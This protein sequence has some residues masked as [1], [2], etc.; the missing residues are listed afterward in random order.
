MDPARPDLVDVGH[1]LDVVEGGADSVRRLEHASCNRADGARAQGARRN[2]QL[3]LW[4]EAE[5]P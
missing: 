2:V 1:A 5:E 4:I 3:P